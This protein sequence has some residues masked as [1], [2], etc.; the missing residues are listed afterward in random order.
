MNFWKWFQ[1]DNYVMFGEF[2]I[3]R[4]RIVLAWVE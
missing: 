1:G 2:M 4:W 3:T